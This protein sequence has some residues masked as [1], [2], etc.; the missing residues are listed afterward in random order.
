MATLFSRV[1]DQEGKHLSQKDVQDMIHPGA[2]AEDRPGVP[3][4]ASVRASSPWDT[5]AEGRPGV[6]GPAGLWAFSL[7][8]SW[9]GPA[10]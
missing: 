4:P 7:W 3:R 2:Q 1:A 10:G 6:L 8:G 9:V 5:K